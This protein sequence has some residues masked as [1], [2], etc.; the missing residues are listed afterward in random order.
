MKFPNMLICHKEEE[1]RFLF[2]A[3]GLGVQWEGEEDRFPTSFGDLEGPSSL[4][5]FNS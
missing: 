2:R 3:K 5:T 1:P 4:E